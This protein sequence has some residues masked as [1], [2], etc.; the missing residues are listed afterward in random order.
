MSL[1]AAL[2][3]VVQA[4]S[5]TSSS[6]PRHLAYLPEQHPDFIFSVRRE[7]FSIVGLAVVVLLLLTMNRVLKRRQSRTKPLD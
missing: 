6:S 1:V 5:S 2:Q 7:Q 4:A 3:L